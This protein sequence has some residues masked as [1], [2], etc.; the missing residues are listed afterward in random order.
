MNPKMCYNCFREKPYAMGPCL[1]CGFDA[2]HGRGK[3]PLALPPGSILNGRY[4]IGRVLGQGGFGITYI[5]QDVQKRARF[6]IKEYFPET[7]ATRTEGHNVT[8]FSGQRKDNFLYGMRCFLTEAKT[9]AQFNGAENIVRVHRYFEE[10]GSAYFVMDYIDGVSLQTY[11]RQRGGRISWKEASQI[12]FPVIEALSL[13]HRKGIVHRDIAPDNIYIT[14]NG[15]VKLLDFGSARYSL[16]DKSRSLDIM[17]KAGYSPKEQYVRR[18]KQGPFTDVYAMAA[19]MY[20][21]LTGRVPPEAIER[22]NADKLMLPSALGSDI[23]DY[24]EAALLKALSVSA[25]NRY[26]TME[27][28]LNAMKGPDPQPGPVPIP[29]LPWKV[30]IITVLA[31]LVAVAVIALLFGSG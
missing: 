18:G 26:Q 31:T 28:F 30:I 29:Q 27:N 23:P 25:E 13:V 11:L 10:N 14:R 22:M 3:Y 21:A 15:T 8:A 9:L 1:C 19:T 6:A 4:I 12:L 17:L 5:A 16:G 7:L 20:H 24:A 2:A